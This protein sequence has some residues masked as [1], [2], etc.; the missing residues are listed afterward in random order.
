[1]ASQSA[2]RKTQR[3]LQAERT[4]DRLFN[5]AVSLLEEMDFEQIKIR[6]IVARAQVSIGTFY[7]YYNTKMEVFYET[8]RI[9]DDYF[10]DTVAP[11]LDQPT[12]HERLLAFF[13]QYARYCS[14]LTDMKMTRL[15]YNTDNHYFNRTSPHGMI[16]VLTEVIQTGLDR[17]E[18]TGTDP[19]GNVA[20]YLMIATRGLVYNWC[21]TG[22]AYNLREAARTYVERLIKA[23]EV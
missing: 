16:S 7:N 5:A 4:K 3:Q 21:T 13:D 9:A 14:E 19:A 11:L 2:P 15:L 8:Y 23:Y 22:G 17:G 10:Q 18:L 6:D 12:T 20:A 1:M